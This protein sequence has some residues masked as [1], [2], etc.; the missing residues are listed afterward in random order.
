MSCVSIAIW[1]ACAASAPSF[2]ASGVVL[3]S[4]VFTAVEERFR[5]E[6]R[7]YVSSNTK[8]L[9]SGETDE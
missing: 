1:S 4:N 6:M 9:E 5:T 2:S 8:L 3:K 7:P